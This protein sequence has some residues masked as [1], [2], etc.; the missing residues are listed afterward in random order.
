MSVHSQAEGE[1]VEKVLTACPPDAQVRRAIDNQ[2]KL[3]GF[4][5][6]L[7]GG[8]SGWCK[9]KDN[10]CW[11]WT[12]GTTV[13]YVPEF[14]HVDCDQVLAGLR[15]LQTFRIA[16]GVPCPKG[17][18]TAAFGFLTFGNFWGRWHDVSHVKSTEA[19]CHSRQP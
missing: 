2:H 10:S 4:Y 13:N 6:G 3:H 14:S 18:G 8:H 15:L 11:S 7:Q 16:R 17:P 1:F 5:T 9:A 12:D 19:A